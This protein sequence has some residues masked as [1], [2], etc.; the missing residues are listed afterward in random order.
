VRQPD[1][2]AENIAAA[3][4]RTL[5]SERASKRQALAT[6]LQEEVRSFGGQP[7]DDQSLLGKAHNKFVDLKNAIAGG[8]DKAV[9]D[10][11]ERGEDVIK[12]KFERVLRDDDIPGSARVLVESAL[13]EIRADHDTVSALKHRD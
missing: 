11:V 3:D 8:S 9:I 13:Q 4:L 5:F 7:E 2:S 6:R 1:N 10:E 12:A